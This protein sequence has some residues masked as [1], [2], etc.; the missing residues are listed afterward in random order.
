MDV[1]IKL[2]WPSFKVHRTSMDSVAGISFAVP[3]VAS[4]YGLLLQTSYRCRNGAGISSGSLNYGSLLASF[5][6]LYS[7]PFDAAF[8]PIYYWSEISQTGATNLSLE[9]ISLLIDE[10]QIEPHQLGQAQILPFLFGVIPSATAF[11]RLLKFVCGFLK[12][13]CFTRP[14]ARYCGLDWSKRPWCLLHGSHPPK[15]SVL[16]V[17][18]C[19]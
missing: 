3:M 15:T 16:A 4:A 5:N 6:A 8:Y 2:D 12:K 9:E 10:A 18:G 14:R 11:F 17:V 13:A 1:K 19:V 7:S